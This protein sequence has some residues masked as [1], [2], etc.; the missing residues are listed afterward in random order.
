MFGPPSGGCS[1][2]A[3]RAAASMPSVA[4]RNCARNEP[5]AATGQNQGAGGGLDGHICQPGSPGEG[6]R[7][8]ALA[9]TR[10]HSRAG[11]ACRADGQ[12]GAGAGPEAGSAGQP[13]HSFVHCP[14][15]HTAPHTHR[16][17]VRPGCLLV[18]A[19]GRWFRRRCQWTAG[20][21][22]GRGEG[23]AVSCPG[24]PPHPQ[25]NNATQKGRARGSMQAGAERWGATSPPRRSVI[26]R[27]PIVC[28][29]I[30]SETCLLH[31]EQR[32]ADVLAA[33][34]NLALL[35]RQQQAT[36]GGSRGV[37]WV[38]AWDWRE[39]RSPPTPSCCVSPAPHPPSARAFSVSSVTG[40]SSSTAFTGRGTI[41]SS[42]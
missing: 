26:D 14:P 33:R 11:Q 23:H 42:S 19:A 39:T 7:L 27:S 4:F 29:L 15:G 17:S 18:S 3:P 10:L 21:A 35:C 9:H 5:S 28:Q 2:N 31:V 34:L 25:K 40:N 36:A 8:L 16:S 41:S 22:G 30:D 37:G 12:R 6:G 1:R 32:G 24:V 20:V 13:A 38:H